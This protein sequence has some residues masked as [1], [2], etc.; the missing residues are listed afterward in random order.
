MDALKELAARL[1]NSWQDELKRIH[2]G[3]QIKKGRFVAD[4]PEYESLDQL[5]NDGD[6][7]IDIGAN[8]GHYTKKF[9]ELVGP[10]GRV[11]AFEPV[12]TTFSLLAA[13]VQKF[14]LKN[15]S[16]FNAA[17]SDKLDLAG[18]AV[19]T[20]STGLSNYYP[21]YLESGNVLYTLALKTK[22]LCSAVDT[23]RE[24]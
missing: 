10:A 12:P 4:E 19:P 7:V 14:P 23:G 2:Y 6:W 16:L 9:S 8:V 5:I 17:V 11:I 18:M 15:V 3:G 24:C 13:N 1:P 22:V 20:F 21:A